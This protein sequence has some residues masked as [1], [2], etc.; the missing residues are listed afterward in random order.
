MCMRT[1]RLPEYEVAWLATGQ[2]DGRVPGWRKTFIFPERGQD[3]ET[4]KAA[5]N[6]MPGISKRDSNDSDGPAR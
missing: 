3:G 1:V 5:N 6:A 2:P 4:L